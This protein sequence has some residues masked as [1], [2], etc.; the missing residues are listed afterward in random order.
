VVPGR[1]PRRPA[2][3]PD[4]RPGAPRPPLRLGPPVCPERAVGAGPVPPHADA[5]ATGLHLAEIGRHTTPAAHAVLA[6]DGTPPP[7]SPSPTTSPSCRWRASGGTCGGTGRACASGPTARPASRP[8][9]RLGTTSRLRRTGSP[10]SPAASGP[11]RSQPRAV[12]TIP[13][14]L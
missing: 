1:G 5:E 3:H 4:A 14:G 9:A 6:P 11:K 8:A 7:A 13:P 2:G 12:G 10:R